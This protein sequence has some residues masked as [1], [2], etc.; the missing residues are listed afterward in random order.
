M[1]SSASSLFK[2]QKNQEEQK[3]QEESKNQRRKRFLIYNNNAYVIRYLEPYIDTHISEF[4]KYCDEIKLTSEEKETV[5]KVFFKKIDDAKLPGAYKTLRDKNQYKV[6]ETQFTNHLKKY[7][8]QFTTVK[9]APQANYGEF[10][11]RALQLSDQ[12]KNFLT[13]IQDIR[14]II[15]SYSGDNKAQMIKDFNAQMDPLIQSLTGNDY[16]KYIKEAK[17][18]IAT[19]LESMQTNEHN[20]YSGLWFACFRKSNSSLQP[21]INTAKAILNDLNFVI[22]PA[23]KTQVALRRS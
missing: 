20:Y 2:Q 8:P 6:D 3:E 18:K 11:S 4:E 21:K 23:A 14:A 15:N 10:I 22:T 16:L 19:M 17:Q 1:A 5:S 13:K 12:K 9:A 7:I